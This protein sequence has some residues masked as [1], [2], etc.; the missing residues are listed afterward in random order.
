[1]TTISDMW[2][3]GILGIAEA[4]REAERLGASHYAVSR[5]CDLV[6]GT[7]DEIKLVA[8]EKGISCI[9]AT[10]FAT[11]GNGGARWDDAKSRWI[12]EGEEVQ[13]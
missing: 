8:A 7:K 9:W 6:L 2:R 5:F 10:S 12:D 1:M 11:A 3:S 4:R 13:P